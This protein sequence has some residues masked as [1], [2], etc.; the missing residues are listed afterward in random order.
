MRT[1]CSFLDKADPNSVNSEFAGQRA[2][3]IDSFWP[4]VVDRRDSWR[5]LSQSRART[6][7]P[8]PIAIEDGC[9]SQ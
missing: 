9:I 7:M 1:W 8:A 4:D 3:P 6:A 5:L 2:E